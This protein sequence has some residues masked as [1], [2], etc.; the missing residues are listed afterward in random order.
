MVRLCVASLAGTTRCSFTMDRLRLFVRVIHWPVDNCHIDATGEMRWP[1]ERFALHGVDGQFKNKILDARTRD[2]RYHPYFS[3]TEPGID[4][5]RH[6][7]PCKQRTEN[8]K[9]EAY[10][11]LCA[12]H[13][14]ILSPEVGL[15]EFVP[16]DRV[17]H[18]F[19]FT[20]VVLPHTE[21]ERSTK[22]W[23]WG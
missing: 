22:E 14:Y 10:I 13:G 16:V 12:I 11:R 21:W 3:C 4:K 5:T 17:W 18:K 6:Y 2:T 15:D 23:K 19:A 7:M 1:R 8:S 20:G 9:Q